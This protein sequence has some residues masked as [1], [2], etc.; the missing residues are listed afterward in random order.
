[1]CWDTAAIRSLTVW[2]V[3]TKK[4][5]TIAVHRNFGAIA[6]SVSTST[7]VATTKLTVPT[8]QTKKIAVRVVAANQTK[9]VFP[10][11]RFF[12]TDSV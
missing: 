8:G 3:G 9:N 12:S 7:L 2:T 1:M 10:T 11:N 5:A 4:T 6:A